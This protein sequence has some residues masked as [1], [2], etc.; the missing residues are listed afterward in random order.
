MTGVQT[1]ALPIWVLTVT[2]KGN[3]LV[4]STWAYRPIAAT[5]KSD[6]PQI[7][8]ATYLSYSPEDSPL[9]IAEGSEKIE[10]Q[11]LWV[12]NDFFSI[13]N[14]FVFIEGEAFDAIES[15]SGIILSEIVARKLFGNETALGKQVIID[16]YTKSIYEVAGVM[17]IPANSHINFGY[18]IPEINSKVTGYSNHW[19]DNGHVHVYFKL[20]QNAVITDTFLSELTRSEERRGGKEFR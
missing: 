19:G 8:Y 14:G 9:Q 6:Y 1:C 13:F 4:K 17:R 10:A 18:I 2:K 15:P 11:E 12:S 7:E 20:V 5:L 3:E 16:K